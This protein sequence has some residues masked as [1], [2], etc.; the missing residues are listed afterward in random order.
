MI[1]DFTN[2]ARNTGIDCS[3]MFG[4]HTYSLKTYNDSVGGLAKFELDSE[5]VTRGMRMSLQSESRMMSDGLAAGM[6]LDSL[7]EQHARKPGEKVHPVIVLGEGRT[8]AATGVWN[9][10]MLLIEKKYRRDPVVR[11]G[12]TVSPF[13][14][15]DGGRA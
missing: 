8:F 11:I 12:A 14:V 1:H 2:G 13:R 15:L 9:A 10:A 6:S 3:F 7:L 5:T 4:G